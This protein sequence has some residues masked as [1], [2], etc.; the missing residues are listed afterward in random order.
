MMYD[1]RT[2]LSRLSS[3]LL[4]AIGALA[5]SPVFA[6]DETN[7]HA[8]GPPPEKLPPS[9]VATE[10][11][12]HPS[13]ASQATDPTAKLIQF[14]IKDTFTWSQHGPVDGNS[15]TALLQ[16]VIP[17]GTGW[18]A[19]PLAIFRPAVPIVTTNEGDAGGKTTGLGD[20]EL[21]SLVLGKYGKRDGY[22]FGRNAKWGLGAQLNSNSA[23]HDET[24]NGKWE[25]GPAFVYFNPNTKG[26]Q[27]GLLGWQVW[28]FAGS[29]NRNATSSLNLQPIVTKHFKKGW[30]IGVPDKVTTYN[31]KTENWSLGFIGGKVGRVMLIGAQPW[32]ISAEVNAD[33]L[34]NQGDTARWSATINFTMLLP[35]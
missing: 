14:T 6:H 10:G 34:S 26:F 24:G 33:P 30:Y 18:E 22:L 25:A 27:W 17:V 31:W 5:L 4:A 12:T 13:L 20:I 8:P 3:L 21:L 15:N 29:D 16:P 35:E 9:N 32:N 28:S 19:A 1:N 23:S 11:A 2:H 7:P